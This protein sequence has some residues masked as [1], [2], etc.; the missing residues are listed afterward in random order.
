MNRRR[1]KTAR[2]DSFLPRLAVC[3]AC[4]VLAS[5]MLLAFGSPERLAAQSKGETAP[6]AKAIASEDV[7]RAKVV[8]F[9]KTY[10]ADCHGADEPEAGI[11]LTEF[12]DAGTLL[13]HRKAWRLG[14]R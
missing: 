14:G 5:V 6:D 4:G 2:L 10:C 13:T 11:A 12:K 9:V 7:F 1:R 3:A 8:P